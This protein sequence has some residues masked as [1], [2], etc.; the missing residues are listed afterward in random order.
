MLGKEELL[1]N[2]SLCPRGMWT[3]AHDQRRE[4]TMAHLLKI[5]LPYWVNGPM[6]SMLSYYHYRMDLR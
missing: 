2:D 5:G 3:H 1:N 4:F 6:L